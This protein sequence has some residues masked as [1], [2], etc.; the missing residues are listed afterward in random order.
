M[1]LLTVLG[2][3][4]IIFPVSR[5]Y[6]QNVELYLKCTSAQGTIN[7]ITIKPRYDIIARIDVHRTIE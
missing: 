7:S 1:K 4:I 5:M 6:K 3:H 2:I